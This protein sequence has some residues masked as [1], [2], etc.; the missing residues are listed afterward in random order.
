MRAGDGARAA[1]IVGI[2][3]ERFS[4]RF[5]E[6]LG[7]TAALHCNKPPNGFIDTVSYCEKT[8]IAQNY[9]LARAQGRSE[10]LAFR[11]LGHQYPG[12]V[13]EHVV[14]KEKRQKI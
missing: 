6:E 7:L 12:I 13:K 14:L 2:D 5:R 3:K 9:R 8:M 1:G 10:R 11:L 4:S